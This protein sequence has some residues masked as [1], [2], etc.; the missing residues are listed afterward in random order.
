MEVEKE[1]SDSKEGRIVQ[2]YP[3]KSAV[4]QVYGCQIQGTASRRKQVKAASKNRGKT[5]HYL[6]IG[7]RWGD[8][9][10]GGALPTYLT[11]WQQGV[12]ALVVSADS[13]GTN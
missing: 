1:H 10:W 11:V 4:W 5:R 12:S 9:R 13:L 2:N 8:Q 3:K 7:S 6:A